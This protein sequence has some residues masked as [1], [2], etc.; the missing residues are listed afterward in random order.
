VS[1]FSSADE[2]P[3]IPALEAYLDRT[4]WGLGAMK[5]YIVGAH[6]AAGS[7]V[8]LDIGCGVGHDLELLA[9][10][11]ITAIGVEPSAAFAA[12]ARRRTEVA[13]G[14]VGIVRASGEHLPLRNE[15]ADGC[16]VERV[17][18]H[19]ADPD[20]LLREACRCVRR[21]GLLT[22]FEPDWLTMRVDSDRFDDDAR[23]F[24]NV[25][26]PAVGADLVGLVE[27]VGAQI[28]DVVEEH[29]TWPT[30]ARAQVGINIEAA[31]ARCV[32]RGSM[33]QADAAAW[34]DEQRRRD[35]AGVFRASI[36]KRLVV[37]RV[38]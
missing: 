34:L 13:R 18:Q 30:L 16:R 21:G 19:V 26:Q 27:Q 7:R 17:L 22:V 5:R 38:S 37:A 28:F 2:A 3:D 32:D 36:T 20:A 14:S 9:Q 15:A 25:R 31:L 11:G 10:A 23:W 4:A 33:T 8:V 1:Q 29:S 6:L 24:A 12:T 35:R